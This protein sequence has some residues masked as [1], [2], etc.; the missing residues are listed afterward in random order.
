[1]KKFE[2]KLSQ[3]TGAKVIQHFGDLKIEPYTNQDISP[4]LPIL[5]QEFPKW[6]KKRIKSYMGIVIKEDIKSSGVLTAMNES[7][8]YVGILIYTFQQVSSEQLGCPKDNN[9]DKT[10]NI[11]VIENINS[12]IPILQKKIFMTLVDT[13]VDIAKTNG[14]NY[15]ELPTLATEGYELIREKYQDCIMDSKTFRTYLNISKLNQ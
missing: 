9:L 4:L 12:C 3:M 8:Y 7:G 2:Y 15:M 1:M 14:C 6:D 5:H 13:A 11:F 10:Y